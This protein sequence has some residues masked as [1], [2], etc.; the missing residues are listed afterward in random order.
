MATE[1]PPR[2]EGV[3]P[4]IP[5]RP[6]Q[7]VQLLLNCLRVFHVLDPD[8]RDPFGRDLLHDLNF[9]IGEGGQIGWQAK[10]FAVPF[11]IHPAAG[12]E[13]L[14]HPVKCVSVVLSL[15]AKL[16]L[17]RQRIAGIE[18]AF[19]LPEQPR[20]KRQNGPGAA[21]G[22]PLA[23]EHFGIEALDRHRDRVIAQA[24]RAASIDQFVELIA[25]VIGHQPIGDDVRQV[26]DLREVQD[27]VNA[28][29]LNTP[30]DV[31]LDDLVVLHRVID[32]SETAVAK[33]VIG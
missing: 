23:F 29:G 10:L 25:F 24:V 6:W 2:L 4:H 19:Q 12:V 33:M 9:R 14:E 16:H 28:A 18:I 32:T 21:F 17:F 13:I 1:A 30:A 22:T 3:H 20:L 11:T 27:I 15:L 5:L 26:L 8:V 31:V 7:P